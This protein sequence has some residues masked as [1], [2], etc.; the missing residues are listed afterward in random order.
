MFENDQNTTGIDSMQSDGYETTV[1]GVENVTRK[2][3]GRKAAL[4]AGG[5]AAV[6]A[7]G[8]ITAYAA[9]DTVKNQL[10][11]RVSS[12]EK[13]Y[14][15]VTEKN[16]QDLGKKVAGYYR[17][18]LDNYEK[19][20]STNIKLTYEPSED[21]KSLIIDEL[22]SG[23]IS[24]E[25]EQAKDIINNS[26]SCS[27]CAGYKVKKGDFNTNIGF[28]L[29]E[30]NIVGFDIAGSARN[31]DYFFR[32]PQLK[33]QWLGIEQGEEDEN[34]I[35]FS[36][37]TR[38]FTKIY[39]QI[40]EDPSS[41]ITPEEVEAE[42][43]RYA[44]IW[45]SFAD[46]VELEKKESVDICDITV[47]YTVATVELT[48][49]DL[50]KL[51]LEYLNE[52][53]EDNTL[54]NIL[55]NKLEVIED[56][57][58]YNEEIDDEI[59]YIK[60]ELEE[61]DYDNNVVLTVDTYIDAT[62]TIRGFGLGS[63]DDKLTMLIGKDGSDVRGEVRFMDGSDEEFSIKLN[64]VESGKSYSGDV[65]VT[66]E[67]YD[68]KSEDYLKKDAVIKFVNAELKDNEKGYFNGDIIINI[69]DIDPINISCSTDGKSQE[70]AYEA[71]IDGTDYG[72]V[73]LVYSADFGAVPELP[74]KSDAFMIDVQNAR[75]I[76]LDDYVEK[77]DFTAFLKKM[78]TDIG[79]EEDTADEFAEELS[80]RAYDAAD[81]DFDWDEDDFDIDFD[82]DDFDIDFGDEDEDDFRSTAG[83]KIIGKAD[84]A[85]G[86]VIGGSDDGHDFSLE[87]DPDYFQYDNFKDNMTEEEFN[88]WMDVM[89]EFSK[90]SS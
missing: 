66:Y 60:E 84:S 67:D 17:T 83:D 18:A 56:E 29:N 82:D 7:G 14:S 3:R 10:K 45:G 13:Y 27:L 15:W 37:I 54:K 70:I 78:F 86:A 55:I 22:F 80:D 33:E 40:L 9:S 19:G 59:D 42:V 6:I 89:K 51:A 87:F 28:E 68:Y 38:Q 4:M 85:T 1:S 75:D 49:K 32:V 72:R 65:T 62:G 5:I 35:G 47:N 88:Q 69:P 24:D 74:G 63:E 53:K 44:G 57:A 77:S 46:E 48:D 30:K 64:A 73:K 79:F 21:A 26:S 61:N 34:R 41:L 25:A 50:D 16:S 8:F 58:E 39:Q 2:A 81:N 76:K 43:N 11:L 36:Y 52:L 20:Q 12:P 71:K 31:F 23:G 90:S